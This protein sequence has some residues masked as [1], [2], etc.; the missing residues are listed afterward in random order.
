MQTARKLREISFTHVCRGEPG[1]WLL[2]TQV[3]VHNEVLVLGT[4]KHREKK[5]S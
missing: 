1:K 3:A 4:L 2:V 5:Y